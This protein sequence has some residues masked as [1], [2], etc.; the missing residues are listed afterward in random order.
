MEEALKAVVSELGF[1]FQLKK[2]QKEILEQLNEK[3]HV[4][5]QLPTGFGKSVCFVLHPLVQDKVGTARVFLLIE[6]KMM[7]SVTI[8][9]NNT[10]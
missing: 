4:F 8:N 9:N 10:I 3:K 6:K 1:E 7:I 2:E 5:A